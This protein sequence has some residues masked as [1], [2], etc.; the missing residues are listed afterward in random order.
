[1]K[2]TRH[3]S[4]PQQTLQDWKQKV[5][6][7]ELL[8]S[9][10]YEDV[11]QKPLYTKE[12]LQHQPLSTFPGNGDYRRGVYPLG[13]ISNPLELAQKI[14]FKNIKDFKT[15]LHSSFQKGQTAISFTPSL[16]IMKHIPQ[17][18]SNIYQQHP[19][20][21]N[22]AHFQQKIV[23][24]LIKMKH[25]EKIAGFIGRDPIALYVQN[26]RMKLD[27]SYAELMKTV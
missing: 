24:A 1:M 12:D 22:G 26:P 21:V 17:L 4:F 27:E 11:N 18:F 20:S 25:S 5:A 16:P 23:E 14:H 8:T 13:Y 6:D 9:R 10:T 19:F 15:Q 3:D 2:E 7:I